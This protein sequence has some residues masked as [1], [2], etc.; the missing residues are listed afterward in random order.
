MFSADLHIDPAVEDALRTLLQREPDKGDHVGLP[1]GLGAGPVPPEHDRV[2]VGQD[3]D[4]PGGP[5]G[6]NSLLTTG[7]GLLC[8]VTAHVLAVK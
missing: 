6:G 4:A 3:E 7:R 2:A 1:L 5:P 8:T